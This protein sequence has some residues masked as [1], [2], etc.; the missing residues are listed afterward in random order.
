LI[1]REQDKIAAENRELLRTIQEKQR[2]R[3]S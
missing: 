1:V 3:K 2:T